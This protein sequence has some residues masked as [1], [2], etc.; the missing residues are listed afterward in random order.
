MPSF[1]VS[2]S[3]KIQ[4]SRIC[5]QIYIASKHNKTPSKCISTKPFGV[6]MNFKS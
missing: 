5:I 4:I 3:L 2:F 6:F 1:S